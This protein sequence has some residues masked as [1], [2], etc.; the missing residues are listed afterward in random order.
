M[1]KN[2]RQYKFSR[3]NDVAHRAMDWIGSVQSLMVHTILFAGSFALVFFGF[4]FEKILLMA[5]PSCR[6]RPFIWPS[7]S[8]WP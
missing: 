3:L 2:R 4:N 7:S 6:S 8:R 1:I 5:P